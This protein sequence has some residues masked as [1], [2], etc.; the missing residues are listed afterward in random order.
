ML[1]PTTR[2]RLAC[3]ALAIA[4][5]TTATPAAPAA[6]ADEPIDSASESDQRAAG[7]SAKTAAIVDQFAS[8]SASRIARFQASGVVSDLGA[9]DAYNK[10][11]ADAPAAAKASTTFPAAYDMRALGL[12]SPVKFQNPWGTC[13]GFGAV[14]AAE[15]SIM[16]ELGLTV[17]KGGP[18]DLSERHLSYFSY[19]PLPEG[20]DSGQGGE[21]NHPISNDASIVFNQGGFPYTATSVFSSGIGPVSETTAP[22]RNDEQIAYGQGGVNYTDLTDLSKLYWWSTSGTWSLP[23][24]DRFVQALELEES[25]ILPAPA[26]TNDAGAYAY[27]EEGT[28]AIKREIMEGRAV[29]IGF[30]A[31]TSRPGQQSQAKYINTD[32][33][34]HYTYEQASV[35]HAVTIVGWDDSYSKDNFIEGHEPPADGAWIVK[36]SWGSAS[37][38][39]PHNNDWG[40]DGYFYLSYYDQT[41]SLPETFD[42]D[43]S[44]YGSGNKYYLVNQYDYMPSSGVSSIVDAQPTSMA[45]V[46]TAEEDMAVRR[47]SCETGNMGTEVEYRLYLL[48]DDAASPTDGVMAAQARATYEYG[49]YHRIDLDEPVVMR[50]GQRYSVV[51]TQKLGAGYEVVVDKAIN[52]AGMTFINRFVSGPMT[53]LDSHYNRYAV[54]IVNEGE[55]YTGW[56]DE[57]EDW[58]ATVAQLK[59]AE[60]AQTGMEP[61]YDYDN[62]GIKA[63]A[64]PYEFP[65]EFSD[66]DPAAWYAPGVGFCVE[67]GLMSGYAGTDRFGV[68]DGLTRAQLATILWRYAE[69]E[70][71]EAY[72][73]KAA[74]E[75]G[76]PDVAADQ[77]YTAAA[78]WAVKNGVFS[79]VE[80]G[81]EKLFEPDRAATFAEYLAVISRFVDAPAG[82]PAVLNAFDDSYT[83]PEWARTTVAWAVEVGLVHGEVHGDGRVT[84][85]P[86][87]AV[88]RERAATVFKNAFDEGVIE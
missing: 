24:E 65:V 54:G 16:S 33:W 85:N 3:G 12:V 17:D 58:S 36:N 25:S 20:D 79:G 55:S 21:G 35:T 27:N 44:E 13:W 14:A 22:Y 38:E 47:L 45:N 43:T 1:K 37:N 40:N 86:N 29:E 87:E 68:G 83:V 4:L 8:D 73:G 62:F 71:A 57:W 74:N 28:E 42:F 50:E 51:V 84:I 5:A 48:D 61:L 70:E 72:D 2:S 82:D 7:G 10:G 32:T 26:T 52:H 19:T 81:S 60:S 6:F 63:Y 31:D 76:M 53:S 18:V 80:G 49:G 11:T 69:P 67:K 41:I 56:G 64:D 15:A 34:A 88:A 9:T 77:Y 59:A 46:F 75:T 66:V 23:E 78:N 30:A 39:W